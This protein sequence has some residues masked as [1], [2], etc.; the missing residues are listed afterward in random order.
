MTELLS[1]VIV[2]IIV[3]GAYLLERRESST[4]DKYKYFDKKGDKWTP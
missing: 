2:A 3:G 1:L 4:D